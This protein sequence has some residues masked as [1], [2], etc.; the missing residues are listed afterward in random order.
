VQTGA[1]VG[2]G[3]SVELQSEAAV[4]AESCT[5]AAVNDSAYTSVHSAI[6]GR[7]FSL[8]AMCEKAGAQR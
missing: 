6:V 2:V 4:G 3:T 8:A 7:S 5:P 1:V